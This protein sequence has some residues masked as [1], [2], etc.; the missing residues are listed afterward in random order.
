MITKGKMQSERIMRIFLES[1]FGEILIFD[2][3][4]PQGQKLCGNG[5]GIKFSPELSLYES[6]FIWNFAFIV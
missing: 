5:A 4:M 3:K 6:A 1:E 2:T